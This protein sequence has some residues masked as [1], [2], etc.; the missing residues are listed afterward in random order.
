M[1]QESGQVADWPDEAALDPSENSVAS[2]WVGDEV[3]SA[4]EKEMNGDTALFSVRIDASIEKAD[5]RWA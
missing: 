4:C 5:V 1:S 3:E 2:E